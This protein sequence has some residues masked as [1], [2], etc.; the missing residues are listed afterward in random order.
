MIQ[1]CPKM[2]CTDR[3]DLKHTPLKQTSLHEKQVPSRHQAWTSHACAR[4]VVSR[5]PLQCG[6]MA[7]A[8][9]MSIAAGPPRKAVAI[10]SEFRWGLA[11]RLAP[12]SAASRGRSAVMVRLRRVVL[13]WRRLSQNRCYI[14]SRCCGG[15]DAV[16]P[17]CSAG[18][19]QLARR[20]LQ[21]P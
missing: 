20:V 7:R 18:G 21:G 6:N 16:P 13:E 19:S 5:P 12:A 3:Q 14:S 17:H 9:A 15:I 1:R 8:A 11:V 2:H 4:S 10:V